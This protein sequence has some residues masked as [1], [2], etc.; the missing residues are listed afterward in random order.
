MLARIRKKGKDVV[1]KRKREKTERNA[2]LSDLVFWESYCAKPQTVASARQLVQQSKTTRKNTDVVE[3]FQL[4]VIRS[5]LPEV[6]DERSQLPASPRKN[7]APASPR[8]NAG[9]AAKASPRRV[10]T[11]ELVAVMQNIPSVLRCV[12]IY[13]RNRSVPEPE[14]EKMVARMLQRAAA[15]APDIDSH[16]KDRQP[17]RP[18][19]PGAPAKLTVDLFRT[20]LDFA[21]LLAFFTGNNTHVPDTHIAPALLECNTV[22]D[23]AREIK[24][25]HEHGKI[26]SSVV[27]ILKTFTHVA[28]TE[29]TL[30]KYDV[31]GL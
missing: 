20:V 18:H 14:F 31:A 9:K 12:Q 6:F 16:A 25:I 17:H 10:T 28:G 4:F 21:R 27:A 8:K 29:N 22:Q 15:H 5:V 7:A 1:E 26:D 3:P 13:F 23:L 11:T 30:A 24:T 2:R 19:E